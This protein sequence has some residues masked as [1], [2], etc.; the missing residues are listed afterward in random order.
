M[1]HILN[2]HE[3]PSRGSELVTTVLKDGEKW[4]DSISEI[5]LGRGAI[6]ASKIKSICC[7]G[8]RDGDVK[9]MRDA[10]LVVLGFYFRTREDT[11]IRITRKDIMIDEE[12]IHVKLLNRKGERE[13]RTV[14]KLM[15]YESTIAHRGK[16]PVDLVKQW[17]HLR[18]CWRVGKKMVLCG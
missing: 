13:L 10:A 4:Q 16:G 11:L 2:G 18:D 15:E 5:Q 3:S 17:I 7:M 6:P 8:L 14:P 9:V 1:F 12:F